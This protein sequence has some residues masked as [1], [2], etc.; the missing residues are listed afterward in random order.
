MGG[1]DLHAACIALPGLDVLDLPTTNRHRL[2]PRAPGRLRALD[3]RL[4]RAARGAVVALGAAV[5]LGAISALL[6]IAQATLLSS[7]IAAAVDGAGA[8]A[9]RTA[10]IALAAVFAGRAIAG[11]AQQAAAY[12]ASVSVKSNLRRRL[13]ERVA[14]L[15]P[16]WSSRAR[17]GEVVALATRG[18]D[19]LDAYFA[20]YLPQLALAVIVPIAVVVALATSDLLAA[21]TVALTVPLVPAF[22]ALVGIASERSTRGRWH[23]LARLAHYFTDVVAGLPTL[24]VFG[25]SRAQIERLRE[26]TDE[27]RRESLATLRVAFLSAFVLELLAALSVALV[28]VG[29][30]LRLLHGDLQLRTALFVLL[31]APEAYLPLRQL[32]LH[33]HASEEGL[34]A[35]GDALRF[36]ESGPGPAGPR[37]PVPGLRD[38]ELRVEGVTVVH[39]DRDLAAPQRASFGVRPGEIV[40]LTGAS[41]S[42]KTTLLQVILGLWPPDSGRVVIEGRGGV[43]DLDQVD[44]ESWRRR[45]AWVSQGPFL[46]PGSVAENIRLAAPDAADI[47]IAQALASVGLGDVDRSMELGERGSGLSSGQRRRVAVAR[48]LLRPG[49]ELLLLDEPTAGLDAAS[50]SAVLSAVVSAARTRGLAV[51]LVAHRPASLAIADRVVPVFA[52]RGV[53]G[54]LTPHAETGCAPESAPAGVPED[55]R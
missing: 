17:S 11:W 6:A 51:I 44:G 36:I 14:T 26:V 2:D 43:V 40:A 53:T 33:Y 8:S 1:G 7:A 21:L 18:L 9:L 49:T 46:T 4:L 27:Y 41:G 10:L 50:E 13:V 23:A 37:L 31:L 22:M 25:R 12:R 34:D 15:G 20:R 47:A 19:A 42:G 48:A 45:V 52:G 24:K 5:A 30:G 32:G 16:R 29:V 3:A 28:A 38:G 35:A 39:P 55:A 54:T